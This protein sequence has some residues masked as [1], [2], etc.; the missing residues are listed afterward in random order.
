MTVLDVTL[1]VEIA[2][3]LGASTSTL[4][5]LDDPTRGL[6]NTGTLGDAAVDTPVWTD[7]TAYVLSGKTSRGASRL[8]GPILRYEAGTASIVL[9]NRDRR[10][11]PSNLSGPY[12]SAGVT[13]V[14]AMRAIRVRAT[15]GGTTYDLFR[16]YIDAW[17]IAWEDPN[18]STATVTATDA[19]KV[20]AS[21]DRVAVATVGAGED[22][23]ARVGRVLDSASWPAADR[24]V[25]TGDSTL[26]AT[27]LSGSVLDELL[28]DAD[29]ELGE[30]Y[31]DGGG[32]IVFRNRTALLDTTRS[33]TSQAT[34]GDGGGSE[35]PYVDLDLANDDSTF[36]NTVRITRVGG[37]AQ[38]ATDSASQALYYARTFTND[39]IILQTDADALHYAQWLLAISK[40][41][42][43]RFA[44]VTLI[45]Q[46][47]PA[48]LWPQALGREL[49]DRITVKRRPPGG[50]SVT[51]KDEFVRG[52]DH[53]FDPGGWRTTWTLQSADKYGSFLTLDNSVLGVLD[54]NKLAY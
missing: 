39:T 46:A 25:D 6:L 34:F 11:D 53:E 7:V 42:E 21:I 47:D 37:S 48:N 2:F 26:Q 50:G 43:L 24:S 52:I 15:Y 32:R 49:G 23:G 9:D 18:W 16:G 20:L 12:V 28:L 27:D 35:L 3:S 1:S 38:T 14:T 54:T 31:V 41:P 45:P 22:T 17:D 44:S 19:F 51:T 33:N 10:F 8:D 13:E 30:L 4:L 36:Y 5:H 40:D 29:S